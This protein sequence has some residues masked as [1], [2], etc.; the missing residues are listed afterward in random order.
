M[1]ALVVTYWVGDGLT[2]ATG[3]RPKVLV[4]F[5]NISQVD[6]TGQPFVNLTPDP[7]AYVVMIEAAESVVDQIEALEH[8]V[9]WSE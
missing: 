2:R 4:D 6:V 8:V 9:I 5:P 1:K 3:F 7:N